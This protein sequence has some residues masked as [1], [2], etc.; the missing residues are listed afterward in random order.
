MVQYRLL[1]FGVFVMDN[2]IVNKENLIIQLQNKKDIISSRILISLIKLI[3]ENE[4]RGYYLSDM[5]HLV[6]AFEDKK[7]NGD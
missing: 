4:T 3:P 6:D 1:N 2:R 7:D 5:Q